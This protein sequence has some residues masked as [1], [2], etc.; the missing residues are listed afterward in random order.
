MDT[1]DEKVDEIVEDKGREIQVFEYNE[2]Q[3]S[4]GIDRNIL[5]YH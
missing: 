4:D 1:I 5:R 2:A 3:L